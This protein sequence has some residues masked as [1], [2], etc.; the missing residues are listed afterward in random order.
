MG[1]PASAARPWLRSPLFDVGLLA[2]CWVPVYVW[3]VFGLG[4]G[5]DGLGGQPLHPA[6]EREAVLLAV[7]VVLGL[8]WVHRHYTFLLVYGDGATFRE[9]AGRYVLAPIAVFGACTYL[10]TRTGTWTLGGVVFEPVVLMALTA[11]LWNVWHTVQQRYGIL[12]AYGGRAGG[13]LREAAHGRR[14]RALLWV[15]LAFVAVALPWLRPTTF[16]LHPS[17]RRVMFELRPFTE[18]PAY[19]VALV[20]VTLGLV[21]VAAWWWRHERR[22]QVDRLP[23]WTFLASTMLLFAVFL[24]HGPVVGYLCFGAAHALEYLAFVHH[25][26]ERRFAGERRSVA[27]VFLGRPLVFAP[28]VIGLFGLA[29]LAFREQRGTVA[30]LVYYTGGSLLHFLYDGWIWKLRR[31]AVRRY[32]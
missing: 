32:V 21:A 9:R 26:S 29:Y 2:F 18:H 10:A 5:W 11:G 19:L 16:T 13:P 20:A 31:P 6:Y 30:Y 7:A 22:A 15:T 12:R 8:T 25:F 28:L 4:L 27:A 1:A 14:D 23:R 3:V 17:A 24:V